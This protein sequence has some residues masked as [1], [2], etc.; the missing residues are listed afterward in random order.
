ME[1]PTFTLERE[2]FPDLL[3][4]IPDPPRRLYVKGSIP[5]ENFKFLTVVGSRKYTNYGKDACEKLIRGLRSYPIVIVS[6]L[7]LGMDAIAH[8]SALDT[9]LL[10]LAFPGSGLG[11]KA[12]YPRSH[13]GL[14]REI[15]DNGGALISEFEET[16][17]A[18]PY[19]FPQRN[20]LMA[21]MSHA[22]LVVEAEEKSGTLI[23][24]KFATEYNRDVLT[25]PGSIFSS[26]SAGPHMLIRLGATPVTRSEDIIEQLGLAPKSQHSMNFGYDD[27]SADE[28]RIIE[29]LKSPLPRDEL[30][31]ALGMSTGKAN[32][33]L[34]VL[35][36]KGIITE[37]MGEIR[38]K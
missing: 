2:N 6:G 17:I 37:T 12:L 23:T 10:T 34:S 35:E 11:D 32:T 7:A 14:A 19:S 27:C 4:Q 38:L 29:L 31:T 18:T 5:D 15:L 30:I 1:Y 22:V 28:K 20:R 25:V 16:F 21:A 3:S 8:R 26:T 24:S 33:L 36:I 13:L 9:G